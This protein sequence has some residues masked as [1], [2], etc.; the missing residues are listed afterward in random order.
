M[1]DASL[2]YL[3]HLRHLVVLNLTDCVRISDMGVRHLTDGNSA[4]KI[5]ELNLTN[6]VRV[7]DVA[8]LRLSQ[9]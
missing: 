2:R 3:A 1:G 7:S 4:G 8:M 9:K 5:R 6:C